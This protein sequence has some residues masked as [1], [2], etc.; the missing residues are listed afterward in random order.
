[1]QNSSRNWIEITISCGVESF[2]I[3]DGVRGD[4]YTFEAT[5]SRF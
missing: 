1:M 3:E 5:A 2:E 4:V